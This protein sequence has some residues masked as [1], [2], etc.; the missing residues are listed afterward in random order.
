MVAQPERQDQPSKGCA[1]Y[2]QM[3]STELATMRLPARGLFYSLLAHILLWLAI[4]YLPWSYWLPRAPHL[5]LERSLEKH[6]VLLLPELVPMGSNPP[7][8]QSSSRERGKPSK[9]EAPARSVEAKAVQGVVYKGPQLIV[10]NPPHPDNFVQTIRQPDIVAPRLPA[11]MPLPAMVSIAPARPV[12]VPPAPDI[13]SENRPVELIPIKLPPEQPKVEA[14]KLPLPAAASADAAR[15]VASTGVPAPVPALAHQ[16]P[17][18]VPGSDAQNILIVEA[19]PFQSPK[20]LAVPPGELHG[21]F[22]VSPEGTPAIGSA[23]GGS[24]SKGAPGMGSASGSS[25]GPYA[26]NGSDA[27]GRNGE[28]N[29]AGNGV[30]PGAT[31]VASGAAPGNGST[32]AGGN[33]TSTAS[34]P[35]GNGSGSLTATGTGH[36]NNPFPSILIQGGSARR[37]PV[38]AKPQTSYGITV[39]AS[40][41]SGGG[42][43]DFGV[44]RNETSYTVY[45]DMADLGVF[46]AN[47]ILQYS[48][49]SHPA[50]GSSAPVPRFN[51]ALLPPYAKLKSVPRFPAQAAQQ[52]RGGMIVVSG[53]INSEGKFEHLQ[54][55]QSPDPGLNQPLLDSLGKWTFQS[56]EIEGI[57]VAVKVLLGVPVDSL[58]Q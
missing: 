37:A 50:P 53:L 27:S 9:D 36:G 18:P 43:K 28:A 25:T 56:A 40:G 33:A 6:E 42:L 20:P 57:R 4:L 54:I 8:A 55:M 58:S 47:W 51:G 39:V 44:F 21:S 10:S 1:V 46:G 52:G 30:G 19:I 23:G 2:P 49:D 12:F 16:A 5:A 35:A 48:L 22:T 29:T 11:P 17:P 15:A 13:V 45:L 3:F 14:P 7:A 38:P 24:E 34:A 31:G 26:G 41:S 32:G